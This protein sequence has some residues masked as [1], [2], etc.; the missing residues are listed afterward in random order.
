MPS[1]W[2]LS[3]CVSPSG[4]CPALYPCVLQVGSTRC[5]RNSK[6]PTGGVIWGLVSVSG[7]KRVDWAEFLS[8]DHDLGL[9]ERFQHTD[10]GLLKLFI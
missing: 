10:L 1:Q 3:P 7:F 8:Q 6:G 2:R 5:P 9:P 4:C